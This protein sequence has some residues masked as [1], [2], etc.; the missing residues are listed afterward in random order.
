MLYYYLIKNYLT[1]RANDYM[2]LVTR[3]RSYTLEEI[4]ERMLKRGTMLTKADI[5][6]VLEVYH[7]EIADIISEGDGVNTPIFNIAPA[8]GGVFEGVNDSFDP[9]RHKIRLNLNAGATLR[10]AQKK[11]RS[12]KVPAIDPVPQ[13]TQVVDMKSRTVNDLLTP[14]GNLR[15]SGYKLKIAGTLEDV[16]C[17]FVDAN[18]GNRTKVDT[19]DIITNNPSELLI[20]IPSLPQGS[21]H[22]EIQTQ[23]SGGGKYLKEVRVSSFN[24]ILIV[25]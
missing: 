8:I 15:V 9:S 3:L 12:E 20:V 4:A 2:A 7:S 24:K 13:I 10:E 6:A 17:Y 23:Y 11:I 25:Q 14:G 22:F 21:Y 5:L 1:E 18:T 19:V 16:G